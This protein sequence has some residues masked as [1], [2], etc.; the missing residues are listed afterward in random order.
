M[1][2]CTDCKKTGQCGMELDAKL[3]GMEVTFCARKEKINIEEVDL[4]RCPLCG[5]EVTVTGGEINWKPTYY[6]P[7]SGDTG[8]P[9]TIYCECGLK[10]SLGRE[11][12]LDE[13][14][15]RWNTRK[16]MENDETIEIVK[17]EFDDMK[18]HLDNVLNALLSEKETELSGIYNSQI[19]HMI[20][21]DRM[22]Y[23]N[24]IINDVIDII[25]REFLL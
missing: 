19:E 2:V 21:Q 5:K 7:D 9:Y 10:F 25:K 6:D 16:P 3:E 17:L 22:E 12:S 20:A 15:E 23:K 8:L 18:G 24:E 1:K 13:L 4:K 14:F 11:H